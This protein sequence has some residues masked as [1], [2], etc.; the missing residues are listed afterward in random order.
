MSTTFPAGPVDSPAA[1][2]PLVLLLVPPHALRTGTE[3]TARHPASALLT[4]SLIN[5]PLYRFRASRRPVRRN[6]IAVPRPRQAN[7]AGPNATP[8]ARPR[9]GGRG[10]HDHPALPLRTKA[11]A[12]RQSLLPSDQHI[13]RAGERHEPLLREP[14]PSPGTRHGYRANREPLAERKHRNRPAAL[15]AILLRHSCARLKNGGLQC[16]STP[17]KPL[18]ISSQSFSVLACRGLL[19]AEFLDLLFER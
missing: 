16:V 6:V 19:S 11:S 5:L 8:M 3:R 17:R 18:A 13:M 9:T 15:A 14:N 2:P 12:W 1:P 4:G 7:A 10:Q